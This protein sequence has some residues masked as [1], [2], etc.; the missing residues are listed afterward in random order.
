MEAPKRPYAG[1]KRPLSEPKNRW[2]HSRIRWNESGTGKAS[3]LVRSDEPGTGRN[4]PERLES[5]NWTAENAESTE[6]DGENHRCEAERG[7]RANDA[8]R[9]AGLRLAG[10]GFSD[11]R[12]WQDRAGNGERETGNRGTTTSFL[13]FE[14]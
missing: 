7:G 3:L 6:R 11:W 12:N 10:R 2:E 14:R 4:G 13:A 9:R 1:P 5:G 8:G